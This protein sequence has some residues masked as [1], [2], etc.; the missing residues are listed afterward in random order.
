LILN[1]EGVLQE[2]CPESPG[3]YTLCMENTLTL[4]LLKGLN[5]RA[6][7]LANNHSLDLGEDS[8]REMR[9][10]LAEEGIACL[11][12]RRVLDLGAFYLAGY[13]DVDNQSAA[14]IARLTRQDLEGLAGLKKDKP[15]FAMIHWG[16]EYADRPG[17]REQALAALLE[18]HGV[19]VI[20]GCHSH[21]A[22]HL[23]GTRR[24]CRVFSLGNFLFDQDSL[25][26]SG[27]LLEAVFFP[28]GTY[29]LKVHSLKNLY[30]IPPS[31]VK[32]TAGVSPVIDLLLAD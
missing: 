28:Q 9:R 25:R 1:L 15:L 31:M 22:S 3:P 7:S 5:V 26:V 14:K 24:S 29:F 8:Y 11:E 30:R 10:R 2:N 27:M 32:L 18:D 13:T 17:P 19:E 20:I 12:N 4:P 21:R 23:E 6:L 16:R